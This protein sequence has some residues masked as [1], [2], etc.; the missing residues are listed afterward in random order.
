M[1]YT[2]TDYENLF[3]GTS[4]FVKGNPSLQR[5]RRLEYYGSTPM[6]LNH[7]AI[8]IFIFGGPTDIQ[9]ALWNKSRSSSLED[10]LEELPDSCKDLFLF[11]LDMFVGKIYLQE[12]L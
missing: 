6:C 9:I 8:V 7:L 11:N 4:S 3:S 1:H 12:E 5:D 10:F 2:I